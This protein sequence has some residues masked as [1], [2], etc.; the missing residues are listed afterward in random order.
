[1]LEDTVNGLKNRI[2]TFSPGQVVGWGAEQ[3]PN[4]I[5]DSLLNGLSDNPRL[6]GGIKRAMGDAR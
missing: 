1:V 2:A 4:A 6:T 3:N 5:S